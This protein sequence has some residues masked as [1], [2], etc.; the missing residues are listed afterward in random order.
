MDVIETFLRGK[1]PDQSQCEDAFVLGGHFAAVID[2]VT[3][4]TK[5]R[6]PAAAPGGPTR[7]PGRFAADVLA[8]YLGREDFDGRLQKMALADLLREL[9]AR[10]QKAALEAL[11]TDG[12]ASE[13]RLEDWPRACLL[14]YND[15][16]HE[17][18]SYG[19]CQCVVRGAVVSHQTELDRVKADKR[20]KVGG[21]FLAAGGTEDEVRAHDPGRDA[22]K[23]A[24]VSQFQYENKRVP[25]GYPVLN[26]LG[27]DAGLAVTY[28]VP[29]GSDLVLASDGYPDGCLC[30]TLAESEERL[31]G[32][33][34]RDPLCYKENRQTKGLQAG[35]ESFD[36]RCY[37]RLRV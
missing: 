15:Y 29:E 4:K 27:T 35:N 33:L 11:R 17:V 23:E 9:D 20:R 19:E 36:D 24:L 26:A 5:L 28:S 3:A 13:L 14:L 6:Y 10:L 22:I 1:R 34:E 8:A 18:G 12:G 2:G 16:R 31:R 25:L 7:S 21:G 37:L 32:V 30:G